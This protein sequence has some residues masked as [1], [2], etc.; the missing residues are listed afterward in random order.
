MPDGPQMA[1]VDLALL[2]RRGLKAHTGLVTSRPAT[3]LHSGTQPRVL[4]V[5]A[6]RTQLS[7]E[8]FTVVDAALKTLLYRRVAGVERAD[9]ERPRRVTGWLWSHQVVV[10]SKRTRS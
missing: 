5:I 7:V 1:P 10:K 6:P 8:D 4:P 2:A 3:R 9:A